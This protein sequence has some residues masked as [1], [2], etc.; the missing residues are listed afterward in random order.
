M[1]KRKIQFLRWGGLSSVVQKGYT[2]NPSLQTF[3]TPPA[4]R[5]VYA[6]VNGEIERYL[7]S[8]SFFDPKM[9]K[10]LSKNRTAGADDRISDNVYNVWKNEAACD[11]FQDVVCNINST[12]EEF[13]KVKRESSYTVTLKNPRKFTYKGDI[14]HH[15][16]NRV[17]PGD[18]MAVCGSWVKTSFE[19][20]KK[21]LQKE[22]VCMKGH[23]VRNGITTSKDHLEVFIEKV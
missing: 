7:L 14:W 22:I 16:S 21:A 5:G 12:D 4:R 17:K 15:L 10:I 9:H 6:F 13:E 18:V 11:R 20:C 8:K 2:I 1:K 23:D 19:T 3:H